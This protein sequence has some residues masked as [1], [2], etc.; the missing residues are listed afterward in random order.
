VL[1]QARAARAMREGDAVVLHLR[2]RCRELV[3][4]RVNMGAC[5]RVSV[6]P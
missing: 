2:E 3:R 5:G 4:G 6:R 1:A